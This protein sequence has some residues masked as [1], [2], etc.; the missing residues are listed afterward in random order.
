MEGKPLDEWLAGLDRRSP[1]KAGYLALPP[2]LHIRIPEL[3]ERWQEVPTD[4]LVATT[5]SSVTRAVVA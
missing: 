2:A 3:P 5:C 1:E 4:R